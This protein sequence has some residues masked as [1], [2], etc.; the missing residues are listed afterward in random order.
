MTQPPKAAAACS[1]SLGWGGG[2]EWGGQ[3]AGCRGGREGAGWAVELEREAQSDIYFFK[4]CFVSTGTSST[5]VKGK[6][7]HMVPP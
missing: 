4:L 7:L 3:A 2:A 6:N 5:A 1:C